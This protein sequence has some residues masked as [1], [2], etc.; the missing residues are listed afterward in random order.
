MAGVQGQHWG[1][2]MKGGA[3]TRLARGTFS[4]RGR[5]GGCIGPRPENTA[6]GLEKSTGR[7][8]GIKIWGDWVQSFVYVQEK[9]TD[10][11]KGLVRGSFCTGRKWKIPGLGWSKQAEG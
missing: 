8:R 2:G 5:T 6:G 11:G 7:G 3:E 9:G 1:S 10:G 4:G